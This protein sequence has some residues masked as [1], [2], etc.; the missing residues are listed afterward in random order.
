MITRITAAVTLRAGDAGFP[1]DA[2][3]VEG[4]EALVLRLREG[5]RGGGGPLQEEDV[6]GLRFDKGVLRSTVE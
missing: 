4:E 1:S 2:A 6:R 3:R 5:A